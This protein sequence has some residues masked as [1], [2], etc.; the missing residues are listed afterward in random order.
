MLRNKP[1]LE[2][3]SESLSALS[4]DTIDKLSSALAVMPDNQKLVFR[5]I[6][7]TNPN[8][9]GR[10]LSTFFDIDNRIGGSCE[11]IFVHRISYRSGLEEDEVLDLCYQLRNHGLIKEKLLTE[12]VFFIDE[13]IVSMINEQPKLI[14]SELYSA[15]EQANYIPEF[16]GGTQL[17]D[18]GHSCFN[19]VDGKLLNGQ[20]RI[21]NYIAL[22]SGTYEFKDGTPMVNLSKRH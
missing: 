22:E 7:I 19:D 11:H 4:I 14:L 6:I 20:F 10:S 8:I 15:Y 21:I 3:Q 5:E 17:S 13:T 1:S 12:W 18:E 9:S 16:L 2:N